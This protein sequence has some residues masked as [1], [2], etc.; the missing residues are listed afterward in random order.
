MHL[1]DT[2]S[3]R[4]LNVIMPGV[5]KYLNSDAKYISILH[6]FAFGVS[7]WDIMNSLKNLADWNKIRQRDFCNAIIF[8][9]TDPS[10]L[11]LT[12]AQKIVD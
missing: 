6:V 7:S 10:R 1:W 11:A 9:H 5:E 8:Y 2:W 4:S 12:N 3:G